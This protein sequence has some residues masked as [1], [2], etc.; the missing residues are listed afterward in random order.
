[1]LWLNL[2]TDKLNTGLTLLLTESIL[3]SQ[4]YIVLNRPWAFVQWLQK[5]DIQEE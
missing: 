2:V 1:M 3:T 4:G 5:A